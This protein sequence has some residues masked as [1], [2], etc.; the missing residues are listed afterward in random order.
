M[1]FVYLHVKKSKNITIMK[2]TKIQKKVN[3]SDQPVSRRHFLLSLGVFSLSV[4]LSLGFLFTS[5]SNGYSI[6]DSS[7]E[8]SDFSEAVEPSISAPDLEDHS[9]VAQEEEQ[10]KNESVESINLSGYWEWR[11]DLNMF[12][13]TIIQK[14]NSLTGNY[15]SSWASGKMDIDEENTISGTLNGNTASVSVYSAAWGGHGTATI[16]VLSDN[17]IQW[18]TK[19]AEDCLIPDKVVLVRK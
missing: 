11:S 14:G 12:D 10:K 9:Q 1:Y 4:F 17:K 19:S 3:C 8:T 5:C 13:I 15:N 7:S 6:G 16:T 2:T 18:V